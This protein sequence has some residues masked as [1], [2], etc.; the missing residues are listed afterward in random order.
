MGRCAP[1]KMK[2]APK[3]VSPPMV[4]RFILPLIS[5]SMSAGIISN[6]RAMAG[7]SKG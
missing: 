6:A 4:S 7:V 5:V 3:A 2:P 1:T